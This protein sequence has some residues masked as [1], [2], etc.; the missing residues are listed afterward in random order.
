MKAGHSEARARRYGVHLVLAIFL[1]YV[2]AIGFIAVLIYFP[3]GNWRHASVEGFA[4]FFRYMA[5]ATMLPLAMGCALVVWVC[6][7][8]EAPLPV[9]ALLM[10]L[11]GAVAINYSWFAYDEVSVTRAVTFRTLAPPPKWSVLVERFG[12]TLCFALGGV[13]AAFFLRRIAASFEV[14]VASASRRAKIPT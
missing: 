14:A 9:F 7:P 12:A 5:M 6:N 13:V 8:V 4:W 1:T 2:F 3:F 10:S 11:V